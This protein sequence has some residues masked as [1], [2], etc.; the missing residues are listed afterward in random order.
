MSERDLTPEE[1]RALEELVDLAERDP[2]AYR[3]AV[4]EAR[5]EVEQREHAET[6]LGMFENATQHRQKRDQELLDLLHGGGGAA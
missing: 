4:R 2:D 5:A 6:L 1:I 3:E